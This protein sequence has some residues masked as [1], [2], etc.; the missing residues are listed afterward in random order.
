MS[1]RAT[2]ENLM[3]CVTGLLVVGSILAA[4]SMDAPLCSAADKES[5]DT[6][7]ERDKQ[8]LMPLQ[9]FVGEWRGVGQPRRGSTAARRGTREPDSRGRPPPRGCVT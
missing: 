7:A 3:R 5:A 1:I 8:A 6:A 2:G 9:V 4:T